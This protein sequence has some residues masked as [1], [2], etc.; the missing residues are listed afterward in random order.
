M[1]D[2]PFQVIEKF[3]MSDSTLDHT[4][5]MPSSSISQVLCAIFGF[6]LIAF[7]NPHRVVAQGSVYMEFVDSASGEPILARMGYLGPN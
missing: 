5:K 6:C 2:V 4:H 7:S 3:S 1:L